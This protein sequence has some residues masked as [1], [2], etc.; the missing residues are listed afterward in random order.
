MANKAN[1]NTN[2]QVVAELGPGDSIGIGLAA[3]LSG[4]NRYYAFDVVKHADAIKNVEIF[5]EL[6]TLFQS[7]AGIP[8]EVEFPNVKPKLESYAFPSGIITEERLSASLNP[9]RV[10]NIRKSI[11]N[12]DGSDSRIIYQVPWDSDA[13]MKKN[14]VDMIFSQA[15]LEHVDG[16]DSAYLIMHSWLRDSGFISHTIDFKCHETA[17]LWNGHWR[18]SD[19][20]WAVIRGGRPYLLNRLPHSAH[21]ASLDA[22]GFDIT[23]ELKT[24]SASAYSR[25]DL[26]SR[27]R[28]MT[29]DDLTTSGTFLQAVKRASAA[30]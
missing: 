8:D 25:G 17:E 28:T 13:I 27:F 30:S 12:S 29:E 3:L 22:A 9:D 14:S 21:V 16:I 11:L 5:D 4:A 6:V 15:V 19:P 2:P 18:Y 24:K 7:R 1:F 20:M 10:D 26:A 23:F